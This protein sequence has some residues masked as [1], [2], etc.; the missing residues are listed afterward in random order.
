MGNLKEVDELSDIYSL[1]AILYQIICGE[2][3]C[4]GTNADVLTQVVQR[5]PIPLLER[6]PI[7]P[8]EL[9]SLCERAMERDKK[10]RLRSAKDLA[11]ELRAYRDGRMLRSYRYTPLERVARF[12]KRNKKAF[13]VGA[14]A[15]LILIATLIGLQVRDAMQFEEQVKERE[16]QLAELEAEAGQIKIGVIRKQIEELQQ[17]LSFSDLPGGTWGTR[18][19]IK[20]NQTVSSDRS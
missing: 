15:A 1:G 19:A 17:E 5:P 16:T 10:K 6:F 8:R 12:V 2:M 7:A 3:P 14:T 18:A 20:R 13:A 4:G 11:N 9:V